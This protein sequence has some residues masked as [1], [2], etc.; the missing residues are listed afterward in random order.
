MLR[1]RGACVVHDVYSGLYDGDRA[2]VVH[3]VYSGLCDEP[4]LQSHMHR[5]RRHAD[6]R[7]LCGSKT[8]SPTMLLRAC[9]CVDEDDEAVVLLFTLHSFLLGA[10]VQL[11][12]NTCKNLCSGVFLCYCSSQFAGTHVKGSVLQTNIYEI[13][14]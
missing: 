14:L 11:A 8:F 13:V 9:C 3:D 10:P 12:A 5:D 6:T 7:S 1:L 4:E 2:C